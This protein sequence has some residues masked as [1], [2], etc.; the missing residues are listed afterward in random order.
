MEHLG[1]GMPPSVE[2]SCVT[3]RRKA[4]S[5][6][7]HETVFNGY[8]VLRNIFMIYNFSDKNIILKGQIKSQIQLC[9]LVT[10][11][12]WGTFLNFLSP[13]VELVIAS[14]TTF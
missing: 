9:H 8:Y 5:S 12:I 10:G 13:Y 3:E 7:L 1:E 14:T 6:S 4:C 2:L 11:W